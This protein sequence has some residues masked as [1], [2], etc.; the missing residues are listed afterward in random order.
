[1]IAKSS[2]AVNKF[3][4]ILASIKNIHR[5]ISVSIAQ[6]RDQHIVIAKLQVD[7]LHA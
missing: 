7:S 6:C 3:N 5:G 1:M 4:S 2:A